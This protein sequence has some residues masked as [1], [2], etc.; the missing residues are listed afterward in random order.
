MANN[1]RYVLITRTGCEGEG[2]ELGVMQLHILCRAAECGMVSEFV[3]MLTDRSANFQVHKED[4][5]IPLKLYTLSFSVHSP[6]ILISGICICSSFA[7]ASLL[8]FAGSTPK[9]DF[10]PSLTHA[11]HASLQTV[12]THHKYSRFWGRGTNHPSNAILIEL[13]F[14]LERRR[15]HHQTK[16]RENSAACSSYS[17]SNIRTN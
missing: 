2:K 13:K 11:S 17:N 16:R 5:S 10:A 14:V 3:I 6:R 12:I 1:T 15:R 4:P 9:I 7:L 8:C